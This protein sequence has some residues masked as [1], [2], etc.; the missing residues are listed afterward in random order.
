MPPSPV[1]SPR[2]MR[3]PSL[4]SDSSGRA[5]NQGH[6]LVPRSSP[7]LRD[8]GRINTSRA[9]GKKPKQQSKLGSS[10]ITNETTDKVIKHNLCF[11]CKSGGFVR[12][13]DKCSEFTACFCYEGLHGCLPEWVLNAPTFVCPNCCKLDSLPV[14]VHGNVIG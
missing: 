4:A 10:S 9:V 11:L 12:T 13:C 3:S 6:N 7:R 2:S 8:Q 14:P 5:S 1:Y